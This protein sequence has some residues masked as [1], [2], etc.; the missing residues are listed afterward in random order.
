MTDAK[1]VAHW[2]QNIEKNVTEVQR[3]TKDLKAIGRIP[4]DAWPRGT[5]DRNG[6]KR[7]DAEYP[8]EVKAA[9][10]RVAAL[11]MPELTESL[12][13]ALASLDQANRVFVEAFNAV[14][15][16]QPQPGGK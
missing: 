16:D 9:E 5:P 8:V 3:I 2:C 15:P 14:G 11:G 10:K 13:K 12:R 4:A 1:S 7:L 6:W